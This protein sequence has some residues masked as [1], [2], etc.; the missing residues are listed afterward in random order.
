VQEA[1]SFVVALPNTYHA[2][3][4]TGFN[5]AEAVAIGPWDWLPAGAEAVRKY[6][7]QG[8]PVAFSYD[9]LLVTLVRVAVPVYGAKC[10]HHGVRPYALRCSLFLQ[11]DA[12]VELSK[13]PSGLSW[14]CYH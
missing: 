7:Q 2:A 10:L 5:L 3:I 12:M 8:R 9:Q 11:H 13:P 1:G 6:R 14:W 4:N